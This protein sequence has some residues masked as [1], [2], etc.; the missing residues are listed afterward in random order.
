MS[1][2]AK[3][4]PYL[5][6]NHRGATVMMVPLANDLGPAAVDPGDLAR[7][8]KE[9]WSDQWYLNSN[10]VRVANQ[11]V[12]GAQIGVARLIV[13]ARPGQVVQYVDGD[14]LNLRRDNLYT[15]EGNARGNTPGRRRVV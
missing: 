6:R 1:T 5:S 14:R 12:R 10:C 15:H 3:R 11:A 13:R 8:M 2:H 4:I 9:A 7:L